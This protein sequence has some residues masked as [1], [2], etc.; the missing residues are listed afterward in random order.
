MREWTLGTIL[1]SVVLTA[2]VLALLA[3]C[4]AQDITQ[5]N[6]PIIP[7]SLDPLTADEY[8]QTTALL[9]SAGHVDDAS[10]FSTLDLRDPAKASVMAWRPGDDFERSAFA[11]VKQGSQTFEAVVD[12][13]NESVVSWTEIEGVQPSL[14]TEEFFGVSEILAENAEHVAALAARGFSPD[15]VVCAPM[16]LGNYDIP[17]YRGRRLLKT[18]CFALGDVSTFNRPIEG[19]WAVV[20]LNA[21]EVVEIVD[22]AVIPVSDAPAAIDEESIDSDREALRPVVLDQPNG[23]N[24]TV[25]GHVVEWDNWTLHYRMEKRSGLAVSTVTYRDGDEIRPVL[26]QGAVSELFVPYMDPSGNWYSRTFMDGGEYG[27]GANATPLSAGYDCPSTGLLLD[28]LVP[29]DMGAAFVASDAICIFERNLGDPAWRHF[30]GFTGSG[31]E[32]RRAVELVLRMGA[33]IGNYDY[34]IDW[35]FT[36]DGRIKPR[37]G[38]SGY[39]G[40]KGV[41]AQSMND[42]TAQAD[43]AYG[44]QVAPG[45]VATNNDHFFS[46]RLDVDID[47]LGNSLSIDRLT[48]RDF[49]GPRSGW[50]VESQV[51]GHEQ[52]ALL[53]YDPSRP[54]YWRI[55]NPNAPGPVGNAPGYVLR[56]GNS[57]AYSLLD[58]GDPAQQRAGFTG[59]Q[60]WVTPLDADERYS[61][62]DYVNQSEGGLGLPAWT[63]ANRPIENADIVLWY[64]A[65]FH[66][67]PRTEDFPIMPSVW[68]EFE[69]MP[70]NFFDRNPAL[71]IPTEWGDEMAAR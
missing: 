26:Y 13:S 6:P 30:D 12:L 68:H 38:A 9:R 32:G 66:H 45:L 56:P 53:D 62:G 51:A 19:L 54:A 71:D 55:F 11:I 41:L 25:R 7:H 35:V 27:F 16:T 40:L 69:L 39:D 17:A 44:T 31:F 36:Q 1:T 33:T 29:D 2:L 8:T 10:R 49:E 3:G 14:L 57:V 23:A 15:E 50:V 65:G 24:F 5:T 20:D 47:G 37:I 63:A 52:E 43:A 22:E 48:M 61:A 4:E 28:A 59:H 58:R 60:L 21:R 18:P 42:L 46:I 70:F 64:T 67:V 34:F